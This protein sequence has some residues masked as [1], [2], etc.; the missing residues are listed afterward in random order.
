M[1]LTQG[2]HILSFGKMKRYMY[3]CGGRSRVDYW[4]L[5]CVF[6]HVSA[7]NICT[8]RRSLCYVIVCCLMATQSILLF[9]LHFPFHTSPCATSHYSGCTV[10]YVYTI[11]CYLNQHILY[12]I[13]SLCAVKCVR[14]LVRPCYKSSGHLL[15]Y[16]Q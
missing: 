3:L 15:N 7:C 1:R 11:T 8:V 9:Q 2:N 5:R 16:Y 13:P 10:C 12:H 4:Q 6:V 14:L